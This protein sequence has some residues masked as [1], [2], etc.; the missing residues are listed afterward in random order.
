[1]KTRYVDVVVRLYGMT[2]ISTTFILSTYLPL[3]YYH[4]SDLCRLILSQHVDLFLLPFKEFSRIGNNDV[5]YLI[6]KSSSNKLYLHI[7]A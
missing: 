7:S 4:H 1:M 5:I 6:N 3:L 2:L